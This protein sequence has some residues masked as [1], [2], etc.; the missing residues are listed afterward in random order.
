M[1]KDKLIEARNNVKRLEEELTEASSQIADIEK[2]YQSK[3]SKAKTLN[4]KADARAYRANKT[5]GLGEIRKES[6]EE[7]EVAK[8]ELAKLNQESADSIMRDWRNLRH[9][10]RNAKADQIRAVIG[11]DKD[12]PNPRGI[13]LTYRQT[14][15]ALAELWEPYRKLYGAVYSQI[16]IKNYID[17]YTVIE[18][19][20]AIKGDAD[21][22]KAVEG[23]KL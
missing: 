18:T 21:L 22:L 9:R 3:L 1:N 10:I 5:T 7:L 15:N 2:E 12:K 16:Q 19:F 14:L 6:T 20:N 8:R 11:S 4:D 17:I 13:N 23:Y